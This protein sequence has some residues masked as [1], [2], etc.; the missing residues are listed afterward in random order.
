LLGLYSVNMDHPLDV[1]GSC[2]AGGVIA[3]VY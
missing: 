3:G 1:A 2:P